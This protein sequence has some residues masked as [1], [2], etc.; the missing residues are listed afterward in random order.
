MTL[1]SVYIWWTLEATQKA[2]WKK[3][4]KGSDTSGILS[5]G[6]D[7]LGGLFSLHFSREQRNSQRVEQKSTFARVFKSPQIYKPSVISSH[8]NPVL[9]YCICESATNPVTFSHYYN[10]ISVPVSLVA[11]YHINWVKN[12]PLKERVPLAFGV[13]HISSTLRFESW[14]SPWHHP[15]LLHWS[16]K[17]Q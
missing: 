5:L 15:P 2:M 8:P 14:K 3:K 11:Q 13:P 6:A 7:S 1:C 16:D 9:V 10:Q 17:Q 12:H 4:K